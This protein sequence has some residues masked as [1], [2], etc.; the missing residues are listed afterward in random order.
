M[1]VAANQLLVQALDD[2]GEVALAALL[3]QQ[4][5]EHDLEEHVAELLPHPRVVAALGGVGQLAGL[6]DRVR[7]DRARV[8]LAVPRALAPQEAR[9]LVEARKRAR[10]LLAKLGYG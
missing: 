3:E 1:G 5:E 8:L 4:G 9:D 2:A 6:L 7:H 10:G